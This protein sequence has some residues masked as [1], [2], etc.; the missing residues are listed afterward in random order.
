MFNLLFDHQ[1]DI[2]NNFGLLKSSVL[3]YE[4]LNFSGYTFPIQ[5]SRIYVCC[6][7]QLVVSRLTFCH[8]YVSI[9]YNVHVNSIGTVSRYLGILTAVNSSSK[10]FHHYQGCVHPLVRQHYNLQLSA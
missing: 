10:G 4:Y 3:K 2:F 1:P 9:L 6:G 8:T 7:P 5:P